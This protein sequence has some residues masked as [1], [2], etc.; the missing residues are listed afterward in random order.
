MHIMYFTER[1]YRDVPEEEVIRNRSFFGVPNSFYD[2]EVGARY[3]NEYIDED[4]YA[5]EV[6]FDAI[7]L[8]E[9]HGTPFCMGAVMNVEAA[10]LARVTK[11][12]RIVLLGNPLPVLKHPLRMAEELAMIDLISKGRLVPGW[13]RGAGSEQIFNNANPAYNREYFN[14]AHDVVIAAWTRPGPFRW[15]GKHFNY[16]YINPWALPYQKPHPPIW[17]PGVISPETVVWCAEHRYPYIGLGTALQSTVELWN[18]YG[19]T[20]ADHGYQAGTENFGYLQQI[21]VSD[22]EEKAQ[23]E[24]KA[25]LFGGGAANFSRPEWTLPPGYNSKE[26]IRRL[27]RQATDYGFLGITSEKLNEAQTGAGERRDPNETKAGTRERLK[28]GEVSIEEA[29]RKIYANYQKAQDGLQIIIG[30]PKTVIPKL[31]LILEVLR[32]GVFG[33]F[34]AQGPLTFDQR[35]NSIRLMGQEVLPA[36][37]EIAKGL[38][39]ADPFE[40]APG[41]RPYV[42]GTKID[43]LVDLEALK[44]A[45]KRDESVR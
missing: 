1:P 33:L 38:G 22:T 5:E 37:R 31:K 6:G 10:I 34:Q 9:H 21:H 28:R 27:A 39:I 40:R 36:M 2:P 23:E 44:R 29:K 13:V 43:A 16:R 42:S 7:M 25:A 19:Q 24:G 4:V 11:K 26:A 17:I 14:E 35:M 15:E 18:L 12:A 30:T 41:S 8:N 32:P 20:A 3:Y 45:P